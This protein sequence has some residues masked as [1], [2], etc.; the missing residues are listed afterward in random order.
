MFKFF[1]Q[2]WRFDVL[3]FDPLNKDDAIGHLNV[4]VDEYVLKSGGNLFGKL[5]E[6]AQGGLFIKKCEPIKFK[7]S[8]R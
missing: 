1:F 2:K 6:S 7:L 3:D 4:D 8:C 5:N